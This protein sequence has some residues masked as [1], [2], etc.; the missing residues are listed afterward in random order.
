MVLWSS[1]PL[2]DVWKHICDKHKIKTKAI[3]LEE[4]LR[5]INPNICWECGGKMETKQETIPLGVKADDEPAGY[6]YIAYSECLK[7]GKKITWNKE[8]I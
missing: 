3:F 4:F 6:G 2:N 1:V 7:C 5:L 8:V